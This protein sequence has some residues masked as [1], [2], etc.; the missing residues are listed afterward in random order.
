[1]ALGKGA[2]GFTKVRMLGALIGG[3]SDDEAEYAAKRLDRLSIRIVGISDS[4]NTEDKINRGKVLTAILGSIGEARSSL[5]EPFVTRLKSENYYING[6]RAEELSNSLPNM[7]QS[8]RDEVCA[9]LLDHDVAYGRNRGRHTNTLQ[10]FFA[11]NFLS[12]SMQEAVFLKAKS[13]YDSHATDEDQEQMALRFEVEHSS[14]DD[15]F[16]ELAPDIRE[17]WEAMFAN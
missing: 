8:V 3:C 10:M 9:A 16:K 6:F 5:Y 7:P 4:Q 15:I 2:F 11:L 12:A 1:L 17:K 14:R 13:I